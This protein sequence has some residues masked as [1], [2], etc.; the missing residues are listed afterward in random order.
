MARFSSQKES[1]FAKGF[2]SCLCSTCWVAHP[3]RHS[4]CCGSGSEGAA[5]GAP[6]QGGSCRLC[7][8]A[9]CSAAAPSGPRSLSRAPT[10][11]AAGLRPFQQLFGCASGWDRCFGCQPLKTAGESGPHPSRGPALNPAANAAFPTV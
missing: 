1:C 5:S 8:P 4:K 3:T 7:V 10:A 2:D 9:R 11:S 6:G